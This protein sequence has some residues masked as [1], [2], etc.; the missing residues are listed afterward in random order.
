MHLLHAIGSFLALHGAL[1]LGAQAWVLAL[2][3]T[4]RLCTYMAARLLVD[5]TLHLACGFAALCLARSTV[6]RGAEVLWAHYLTTRLSTL[7][8]TT[9]CVEAFA[10]SRAGWHIAHWTTFLIALRR[11]TCPG[12]HRC[13]ILGLALFL[14]SGAPLFPATITMKM[15]SVA[16]GR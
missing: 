2:P 7:H 10:T 4:N 3:L 9:V 5:S 13:T 12:T 16:L 1:R 6:F 14:H 11:I 8:F 15:S